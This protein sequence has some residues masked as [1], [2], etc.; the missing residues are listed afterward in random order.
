MVLAGRMVIAAAA[1]AVVVVVAAVD[2][3]GCTKGQNSHRAFE[4][5]FSNA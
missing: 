2:F 5:I 1:A 3:G 4:L